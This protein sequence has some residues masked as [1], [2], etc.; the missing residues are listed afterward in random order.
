MKNAH[1]WNYNSLAITDLNKRIYHAHAISTSPSYLVSVPAHRCTRAHTKRITIPYWCSDSL[2]FVRYMCSEFNIN[3]SV[4]PSRLCHHFSLLKYGKMI[5]FNSIAA[6][7]FYSSA[8]RFVL[9]ANK[10]NAQVFCTFGW[11][12]RWMVNSMGDGSQ[13]VEFAG[14]NKWFSQSQTDHHG[15]NVESVSAM[16]NSHYFSICLPINWILCE[17]TIMPVLNHLE[18]FTGKYMMQIH[19]TYNS[20]G[21][22]KSCIHKNESK[23]KCVNLLHAHQF[24][25]YA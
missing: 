21:C 22:H 1:S 6:V 5:A 19:N 2:M 15:L 11:N 25:C 10:Y 9:S 23:K 20:L 13:M 4:Y 7:H 17:R 8:A 3:A 12:Y 18:P 24:R 16:D 14:Q